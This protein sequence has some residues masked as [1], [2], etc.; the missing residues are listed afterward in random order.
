MVGCSR[1][2]P[3]LE[4]VCSHWGSSDNY[5][6]G[7]FLV[8]RRYSVSILSFYMPNNLSF[9]FLRKSYLPDHALNIHDT[10]PVI[11]SQLSNLP[12][13]VPKFHILTVSWK[14]VAASGR[15][16]AIGVFYSLK[17]NK[18]RTTKH[19][20]TTTKKISKPS[21]NHTKS[22]NI[23]EDVFDFLLQKKTW[24]CILSLGMAVSTCE[25]ACSITL[26]LSR[27]LLFTFLS[28]ISI[29]IKLDGSILIM[30]EEWFLM[31]WLG[32]QVA[33]GQ[34]WVEIIWRF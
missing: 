6:N 23:H 29:I 16:M 33:L 19:Q 34:F 27:H 24:T 5:F 2:K 4:Q 25:S 11:L 22:L 3:P 30:I 28:T 17:Q 8:A 7:L 15:K 9:S 21:P 14:W 10:A 20:P 12:A 26:H 13:D 32:L 31:L 1:T 18:T